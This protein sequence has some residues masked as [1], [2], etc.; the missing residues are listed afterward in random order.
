MGTSCKGKL[1]VM[2][3]TRGRNKYKRVKI[4]PRDYTSSTRAERKAKHE[5][6]SK[7]G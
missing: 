1:N 5:N 7:K 2:S 3:N 6:K 4:I